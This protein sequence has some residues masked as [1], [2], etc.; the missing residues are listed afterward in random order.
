M[1]TASK[2]APPPPK[3]PRRRCSTT[4]VTMSCSRLTYLLLLGLVVVGAT[5]NV[6]GDD[7]AAPAVAVDS[8]QQQQQ[9][10][11]QLGSWARPYNGTSGDSSQAREYEA[12]AVYQ[13]IPYFDSTYLVV[14]AENMSVVSTPP[15]LINVSSSSSSSGGTGGWSPKIWSKDPNYFASVCFNTFMSRRAYL[16]APS[17]AA[18]GNATSTVNIA[19][20]GQYAVLVRYEAL[21]THDTTFRV[22]I[23]QPPGV[24]KYDRVYGRLR[25]WKAWAFV[26]GRRAGGNRGGL[27]GTVCGAAGPFALAQACTSSNSS[28]YLCCIS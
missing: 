17:T 20:A 21:A 12:T 10:Q 22:V 15:P 9:R 3:T 27:N 25:N 26:G 24:V 6:E 16:H 1:A 7:E 5:D 8:Q 19:G 18:A 11:Q 28:V 2:A 23:E 14:E 4:T 13:S